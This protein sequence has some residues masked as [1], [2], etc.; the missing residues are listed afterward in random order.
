MN[1]NRQQ[2]SPF[3]MLLNG[4][5]SLL[6]S[7]TL[8]F[9][10]L[11]VLPLDA[12]TVQLM[13]S[14]A[15]P[16]AIAE[17]REALGVDD[18]IFTQYLRY[19]AGLMKGDLGVSLFTGQPVQ[20]LVLL[21]VGATLQLAL[22]SLMVGALVG[23][24]LGAWGS[25][26]HID[27]AGQPDSA[28]SRVVARIVRIF[29]SALALSTPTYW[30]G[31]LVIWLF[32]VRLDWFP[33]SGAGGWEHLVLPS[34]VLGFNI[35]GGVA[36][37]TATLLYDVSRHD[38]IRTGIAKGLHQRVVTYRHAVRLIVP[39]V[40]TYL[41]SQAVFVLGGSVVTEAVF[42]RPGLGRL[43]LDAALRQ[44]YP[45]VQGIVVWICVVVALVTFLSTI[46][47]RRLDPRPV[48]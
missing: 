26:P 46:L 10:A 47:R 17:R 22:T 1:E 3:A 34:A 41:G 9:F 36:I 21:N 29:F 40:V 18:P 5:M 32:A 7:I 12:I 4:L 16:A 30:T 11:R 6:L 27:G 48:G 33:A 38:F 19:V 31:T 8:V 15:P 24:A 44:D 28:L 13:E 23:V 37:V 20:E 45:V 25:V 43:L 42:A 35:A 39:G 2:L 14:G